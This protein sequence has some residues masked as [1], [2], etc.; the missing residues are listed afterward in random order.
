MSFI[1][2]I[3]SI[4]GAI[5]V[6][7]VVDILGRVDNE[8]KLKMNNKEKGILVLMVFLSTF[9][10]YHKYKFSVEFIFYFY[11]SIYLIITA[12]IDYKIKKV[13]CILN[14]LTIFVA[15]IFMMYHLYMGI[16]I[17]YIIISVIIYSCFSCLLRIFKFYGGGD[18]EIYIAIGYFVAS[19]S[20]S[21]LPLTTLMINMLVSNLVLILINVKGLIKNFKEVS[22]RKDAFAPAIA[23]ATIL[24]IFA[25]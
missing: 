7:E 9:L 17:S 5:C 11:L 13:Y 15:L 16:D 22:K 25:I 12:Y 1:S 20:Y 6:V 3:F 24:I 8:E 14:I 23:I 2:L 19:L 18:N 21:H 4:L 10:I